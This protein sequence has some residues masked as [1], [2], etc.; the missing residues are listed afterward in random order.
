[1]EETTLSFSC[2]CGVYTGQLS[3]H[4]KQRGF[5][6]FC[7]CCDCQG[8][9]KKL[10]SEYNTI[11]SNGGTQIYQTRPSFYHV[12]SGADQIRLYVHSSKGLYR[13][14]TECCHT[15]IGNTMQKGEVPFIG[16]P[17]SLI[18][19]GDKT[20]EE[21]L[22]GIEMRGFTKYASPSKPEDG[23]ETFPLSYMTKIIPFMLLGLVNGLAKPHP[24]FS[25]GKPISDPLVGRIHGERDMSKEIAFVSS[26]TIDQGKH[27]EF[28][29]LVEEMI[30]VSKREP[31]TL[32]YDWFIDATK[33]KC[34][35][36]ER[37]SDK[38]AVVSHLNMFFEKFAPRMFEL[39]KTT[40]FI[41][42]GEV[43]DKIKNLLTKA[44]P[45]YFSH[46]KGF[47]S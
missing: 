17:V 35:G 20:A 2:K 19:F 1:M 13:W 5:H 9:N 11:D 28:G 38:E 37:Y 39:S 3:L 31:D 14:Y 25:S 7:Y 32:S 42:Y 10:N 40:E 45:K 15:H 23:Y 36:F 8:F 46:W 44:N 27:D 6:V 34:Q 43:D 24:F 21:V 12:E 18:D 47:A 4:K 29:K 22:G 26:I 33:T 30:S 16:V 41:V